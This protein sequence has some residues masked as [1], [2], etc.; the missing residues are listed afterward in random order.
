MEK[1]IAL[2]AGDGIGPE[3]MTEALKAM[4]AVAAKFGHKF[5]YTHALVGASAIDAVGDPYP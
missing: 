3:I 5:N 4:D 1:K 2:L